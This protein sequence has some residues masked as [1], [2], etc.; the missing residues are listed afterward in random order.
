MLTVDVF[1]DENMND[2]LPAFQIIEFNNHLLRSIREGFEHEVTQKHR[3]NTDMQRQ[4][5][6]NP[7]KR[8]S[9]R[10]DAHPLTY[11][12]RSSVLQ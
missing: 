8:K 11:C 7:G 9:V 2:F 6:R 5:P 3:W 4:S 12:L 10:E 1:I